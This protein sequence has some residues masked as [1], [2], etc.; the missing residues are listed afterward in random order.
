MSRLLWLA[1]LFILTTS[2]MAL[3][4]IVRQ[5]EADL[6]C[7]QEV[8]PNDLGR[9]QV[10]RLTL[11][12]NKAARIDGTE[13]YEFAISPQF[14]RDEVQPF[15]GGSQFPLTQRLVSCRTMK[16]LPTTA[17]A[18]SASAVAG[19]GLPKMISAF[20]SCKQSKE[21]LATLILQKVRLYQTKYSTTTS[22]KLRSTT[23][24]SS[25]RA[26]AAN[27]SESRCTART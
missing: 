1:L 16:T 8:Q 10:E 6:V 12:L 11:L 3:T 24:P 7:I 9:E 4:N 26:Q 25:R 15:S 13:E 21:T 17:I 27:W 2:S 22:N 5:A 14:N 23:K 18:R 20:L 19:Y